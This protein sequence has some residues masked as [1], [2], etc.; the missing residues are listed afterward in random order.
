MNEQAGS[1]PQKEE[2]EEEK[3]TPVKKQKS[4]S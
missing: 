2:S 1:E 4:R 3:Q